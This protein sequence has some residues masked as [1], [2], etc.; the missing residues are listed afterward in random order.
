MR[1]RHLAAVG[2]LRDPLRVHE[3][4]D[5]DRLQPRLG[6]RVDQTDLVLGRDHAGLVLQ[7]VARPDLVDRDLGGKVVEQ[8][9]DFT[10]DSRLAYVAAQLTRRAQSSSVTSARVSTHHVGRGQVVA[11]EIAGPHA[12]DA[13]PGRARGLD[14]GGRVLD[15]QGPARGGAHRAPAPSGTARATACRARSPRRP[16]SSENSSRTPMPVS[17]SRTSLPLAP[18]TTASL[19]RR[20]SRRTRLHGAGQRAVPA[21]WPAS[22]PSRRRRHR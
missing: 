6:Q 4:G 22:R 14:A 11:A 9:P 5:L 2:Q 15:D 3:A 16:R 21:S 19:E 12:D 13:Q 18:E 20:A 8:P 1:A 7:P 17:A 10:T